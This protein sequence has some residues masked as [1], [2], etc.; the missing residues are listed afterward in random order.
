MKKIFLAVLLT[1]TFSSPNF[2]DD[3]TDLTTVSDA[4]WGLW[5]PP[6]TADLDLA[7]EIE[8]GAV[9]FGYF[10]EEP[11]SIDDIQ[12]WKG[13]MRAWLDTLEALEY[14][15]IDREFEV[16]G[17]MG[18]EWGHYHERQ[19][20]IGGEVRRDHKGR[21]TI[22]WLKNSEGRWRMAAYHRSALPE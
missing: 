13:R 12:A 10:G 18:L 11:R 5:L 4:W 6:K 14:K 16:H 22:T 15:H 7:A 21:Y 20:K 9:G 1:L 19:V 2:A 17:N 3:L 8:G